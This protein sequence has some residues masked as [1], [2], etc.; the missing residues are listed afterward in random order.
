MLLQLGLEVL[1]AHV[2]ALDGRR[3]MADRRHQTLWCL[4]ERVLAYHQDAR[5][6][7]TDYT[8]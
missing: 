8:H 4:R 7:Q 6:T 5:G 2:Q 3:V 1:D